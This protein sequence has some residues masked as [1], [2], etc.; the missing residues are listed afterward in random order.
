MS[1]TASLPMA[2]PSAL[3]AGDRPR[4]R[5]LVAACVAGAC[6]HSMQRGFLSLHTQ[7]QSGQPLAQ[8]AKWAPDKARGLPPM[9]LGPGGGADPVNNVSPEMAAAGRKYAQRYEEIFMMGQKVWNSIKKI[10]GAEAPRK[11]Y[12]VGTN[13]N[14][15]QEIAEA[16]MDS[17]AYVPAPD[18]TQFLRRKPGVQYPTI[19]YGLSNSD[20]RVSETCAMLK[21]PSPVDLYLEDPEK[22]REIETR[23]LKEFSEQD[24]EGY[25]AAFVVGESALSTPENVEIIKQGLVV[26]LDV[27]TEWSWGKTQWRPKQGG[28]LFMPTDKHNRP[29]VWCI[30]NGWDGDI[31]DTEGKREYEKIMVGYS[32]G[33]EESAELRMKVDIPGLS[34]NP[35]WCAERLMKVMAERFG[36]TDDASSV[37]EEFL[38]KDLEKFLEGARLS[39][40]LKPAMDWCTEQGAASIEELVES[41]EELSDALALKPLEKKR[42]EKAAASVVVG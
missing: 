33:Y 30:A 37:E 10:D 6:V 14:Q 25:P 28:G 18:G 31:D 13:G 22:Y 32:K 24:F 16:V 7:K 4:W 19:K 41:V 40:Y 8:G 3:R 38:E 1:P 35:Y 9:R 26:W 29:P 39:K 17:L 23:V 21:L 12:F 36:V 34:E 27:D 42:L 15:G 5:L 2:P 20:R 11:V